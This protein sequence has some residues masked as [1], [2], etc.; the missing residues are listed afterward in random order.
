M[1]GLAF[2]TAAYK[3]Q[4]GSKSLTCKQRKRAQ[5]KLGHFLALRGQTNIR[6]V[7]GPSK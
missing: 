6:T 7:K 2:R 5:K 3:R 1:M 4:T